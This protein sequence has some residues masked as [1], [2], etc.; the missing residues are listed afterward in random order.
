MSRILCA[1]FMLLSACGGGGGGGSDP[2][3]VNPPV[4]YSDAAERAAMS[5]PAFGASIVQAVASDTISTSFTPGSRFEVTVSRAGGSS[6]TLN[7]SGTS[8]IQNPATSPVTGRMSQT[9][10]LVGSNA[11]AGVL[12]DWNSGDATDYLAG[13][14][15]PSHLLA[16]MWKSGH[17]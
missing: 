13:G 15:W 4:S 3:P 7:T 10:T 9:G 11:R 14:Y 2:I 1:A 17:S 8:I 5:P 12:V 16:E 6:F